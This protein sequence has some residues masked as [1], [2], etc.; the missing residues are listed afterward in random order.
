MYLASVRL[1]GRKVGKRKEITRLGIRRA[2]MTHTPNINCDMSKASKYIHSVCIVHNV[3]LAQ[4]MYH[5]HYMCSELT[6]DMTNLRK[7]LC[8]GNPIIC[9]N[10]IRTLKSIMITNNMI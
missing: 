8:M 5:I 2:N 9:K 10:I 7:C 3:P 6:H 4:D 1:R